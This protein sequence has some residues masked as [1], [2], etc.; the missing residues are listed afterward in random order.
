FAHKTVAALATAVTDL[1]PAADAD[2]ADSQEPLITLDQ[3]E[4]DE[5]AEDWR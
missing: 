5:F 4:L 1:V 2:E 3:S